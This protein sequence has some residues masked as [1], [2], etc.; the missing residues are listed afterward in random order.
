M[1]FEFLELMEERGRKVEEEDEDQEVKRG[2]V[3]KRI[4]HGQITLV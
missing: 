4:I 2:F 3:K 1:N